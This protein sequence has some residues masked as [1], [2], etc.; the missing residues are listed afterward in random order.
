LPCRSSTV[1]TR[2]SVGRLSV[3]LYASTDATLDSSDTAL[4]TV[5]SS[6]RLRPGQ[7]HRLSFQFSTPL[8]LATGSDYLLAEID[9][10]GAAG[11]SVFASANPVA[12]QQPDVDLVTEFVYL[13]GSAIQTNGIVWNQPW[14]AIQVVNIGSTVARGTVDLG[15]YI[16][17]STVLDGS[18]AR[19]AQGSQRR[20][21]WGRANHGFSPHG[22]LSRRG[23]C[24]AV[25]RC[26]ASRQPSAESQPA[27]P[28]T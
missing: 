21:S 3:T 6:I 18:A 7:D 13:P 24:R 14:A 27:S 5:S 11:G 20:S 4:A 10:G 8:T 28:P 2:H 26:S 22:S 1:A 23:R 12:V 19:A 9:G 25:T 16:S 17:S 15:L